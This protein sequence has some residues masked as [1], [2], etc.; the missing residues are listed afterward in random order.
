MLK[1]ILGIVVGIIVGIFIITVV[2]G[3]GHH[4]Y[5]IADP[6]I[7]LEDPEAVKEMLANLPLAALLFVPLAYTLGSFIAGFISTLISERRYKHWPAIISGGVL[8]LLGIINLFQ[9]PHPTWLAV[10]IV[11]VFLPSAFLGYKVL[12]R[13]KA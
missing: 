5:G 1:T 8:L 9:L 13:S 3:V 6:N 4:L 11:I 12:R 2:Q 7:D 10:V